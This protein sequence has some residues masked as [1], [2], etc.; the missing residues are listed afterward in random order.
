MNTST[1]EAI[2]SGGT[3]RDGAKYERKQHQRA[4]SAD[5]TEIVG[6]DQGQGRLVL[7][8]L[9]DEMSWF[10]L[11]PHL[12]DYFTCYSMNT[13]GRGRPLLRTTRSNVSCRTLRRDR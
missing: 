5:G 12:T 11:L 7:G 2:R 1:A 6:G 8:G 3:H 4:V 9:G 10:V 13:R